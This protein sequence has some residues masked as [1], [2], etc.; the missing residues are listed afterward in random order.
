M[1]QKRKECNREDEFEGRFTFPRTEEKL[2]EFYTQIVATTRRLVTVC[3]PLRFPG[4][5]I[6]LL[7]LPTSVGYKLI[8]PVRFLTGRIG[9]RR[10]EASSPG[11][12]KPA[13]P[14]RDPN[15]P[16]RFMLAAV[17]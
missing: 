10:R 8:S 9:V 14:R 12:F 17:P 3:A 7:H 15:P 4:K 2:C 5:S 6:P 16:T 1:I 13:E 11:P